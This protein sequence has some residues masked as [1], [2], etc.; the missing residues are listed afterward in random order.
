MK[1]PMNMGKIILATGLLIVMIFV[2]VAPAMATQDTMQSTKLSYFQNTA[3][4][5]PSTIYTNPQY[6]Y[7]NWDPNNKIGL[8]EI[9][10]GTIDGSTVG[11]GDCASFVEWACP[12]N[13]KTKNWKQGDHVLDGKV[14]SGAAIATLNTNGYISGGHS[15]IFVSYSYTN[16]KITG[17]LVWDQNYHGGKAIG[18]H[19]LKNGASTYNSNANN[20]YVVQVP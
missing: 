4:W 5:I 12:N 1:K 8:Q 16:G 3:K 18:R 14:T 10:I 20:Y 17:F 6:D 11:T 15:A 7:L 13:V 9:N 19:I 2:A